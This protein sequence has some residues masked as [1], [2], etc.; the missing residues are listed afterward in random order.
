MT[1]TETFTRADISKS[2][3]SGICEVHYLNSNGELEDIAG[4]LR[5][6]HIDASKERDWVDLSY[7]E[8]DIVLWSIRDEAWKVIPVKDIKSFEQLTGVPK[9]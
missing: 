6:F 7:N 1:M 2:L 3:L 9:V 4:T 8:N 5:K